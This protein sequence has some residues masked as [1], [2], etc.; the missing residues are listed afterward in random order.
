MK[1]LNIDTVNF[2]RLFINGKEFYS[3]G[4]R[5]I[6]NTLFLGDEVITLTSNDFV[7]GIYEVQRT[8]LEDPIR[9]YT[10]ET[11]DSIVNITVT[12]VDDSHFKI[13]NTNDLLINVTYIMIGTTPYYI[14]YR[15]FV[16]GVW[17][18]TLDRLNSGTYTA[19]IP[20]YTIGAVDQDD[21]DLKPALIRNDGTNIKVYYKDVFT[22]NEGRYLK[23]YD[24]NTISGCVG[25]YVGLYNRITKTNATGTG[26]FTVSGDNINSGTTGTVTLGNLHG[27]SNVVT[28]SGWVTWN[29]VDGGIPF[30]INGNMNLW[31]AYSGSV[32]LNTGNGDLYGISAS[33]FSGVAK[34]IVAIFDP[35][36]A[37]GYGKLYVNGVLQTLT[38]KGGTKRSTTLSAQ[39]IKMFPTGYTNFGNVS[40][41]KVFNRAVTDTEAYQLYKSNGS[42]FVD[43]ITIDLFT[44]RNINKLTNITWDTLANQYKVSLENTKIIAGSSV[45]VENQII[46]LDTSIIEIN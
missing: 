5:T 17:T 35:S 45:M 9:K 29:G 16:S 2:K 7:N 21:A 1:S 46:E 10:I 31:F 25:D 44:Q 37:N 43:N 28:I 4:G 42:G 15:D 26:N 20:V 11:S 23:L 3:T 19:V 14:K 27:S 30:S 8:D 24:K 39:P 40:R 6:L 22:N 18:Y 36:S 41:V 33:G 13:T 32:G 34:H 12:K 38:Q